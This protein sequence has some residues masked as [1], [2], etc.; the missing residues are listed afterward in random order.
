MDSDTDYLNQPIQENVRFTQ[1][2]QLLSWSKS[3][4]PHGLQHASGRATR[5]L[6][7]DIGHIV[8]TE[9]VHT[10]YVTYPS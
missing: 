6:R 8:T 1:S 5:K 3:L 2:L 10:G 7:D 9:G 4:Q